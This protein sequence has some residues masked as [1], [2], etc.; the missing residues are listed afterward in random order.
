MKPKIKLVYHTR[1]ANATGCLNWINT[2]YIP[3]CKF[4]DII[5]KRIQSHKNKTYI[6][7]YAW[8]TYSTLVID[9]FRL[10]IVD[11]TIDK[12]AIEFYVDGE[13]LEVN[14]YGDYNNQQ[15]DI[16]GMSIL[17]IIRRRLDGSIK[18]RKEKANETRTIQ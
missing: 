12:D 13:K 3:E 17:D 5:R 2:E 18:K 15:E 9:I 4:E 8:H 1:Y 14:E 11:G 16:P 10:L 7:E 6:D